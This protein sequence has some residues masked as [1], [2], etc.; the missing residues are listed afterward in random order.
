M[1]KSSLVKYSLKA[2]FCS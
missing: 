2:A 1:I